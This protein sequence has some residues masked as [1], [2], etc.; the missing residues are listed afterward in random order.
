VA[1]ARGKAAVPG[2]SRKLLDLAWYDGAVAAL[3]RAQ[4][5][6]QEAREEV[7]AK[8]RAATDAAERAKIANDSGDV[9]LWGAWAHG[10]ERTYGCEPEATAEDMDHL[11]ALSKTLGGPAAV[12]NFW[13]WRWPNWRS[14]LTKKHRVDEFPAPGAPRLRIAEAI[15]DEYVGAY[16]RETKTKRNA[17][18]QAP[19][20]QAEQRAEQKRREKEREELGRARR[21][22]HR[23]EPRPRGAG[24]VVAGP[25]PPHRDDR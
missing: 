9:T 4:A 12:I 17:A 11:R 8:A 23:P 20:E 5:T 2:Q 19:V 22:P 14:Y 13:A 10:F 18:H 16:L 21:L 24:R 15:K 25:R 6:S 3:K 1:L 7:L